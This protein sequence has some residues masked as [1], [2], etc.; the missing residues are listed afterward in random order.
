[1]TRSLA[2]LLAVAGAAGLLSPLEA[3]EVTLRYRGEVGRVAEYRLSLKVTGEQ[4]SLGER[5]PVR[6]EAELELREEIVASGP[7]EMVVRAEARPLKVKEPNGRF[8]AASQGSWPEVMVR[9]TGQGEM[10]E[11]SLSESRAHAGPFERAFASLL[12]RPLLVVLP[13]QAVSPGARWQWEGKGARQTNRLLSVS[14]SNSG[15]VARIASSA[16]A[17]VEVEEESA[18]LG[19]TTRVSGEETQVCQ[20]DLLVE[21]GLAVRQKGE[22]SVRTAGEITLELPDGVRRFPVN[23]EMKASFDLRLVRVR[24]PR[25]AEPGR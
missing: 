24:R 8:G 12:A 23:S 15:P 19:V 20:L 17:P 9:I 16:R 3:G 21:A 14:G 13:G 5:R 18:G 6:L 7:E 25:V 22:M 1:M 4:V 11:S 2:G 10:L